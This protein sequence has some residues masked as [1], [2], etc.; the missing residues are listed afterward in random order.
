MHEV[1]RMKVSW[2]DYCPSP[3]LMHSFCMLHQVPQCPSLAAMDHICHIISYHTLT[4][5]WAASMNDEA[6]SVWGW[7]R[8]RCTGRATRRKV[9][10]KKETRRGC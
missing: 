2:I 3:L 5:A 1:D 6:K 7:Y 4:R 9:S 8:R 10:D